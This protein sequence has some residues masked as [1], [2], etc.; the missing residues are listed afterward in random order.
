MIKAIKCYF[1]ISDEALKEEMEGFEDPYLRDIL[2]QL[3]K[4][5]D[6]RQKTISGYCS[7]VQ[8]PDPDQAVF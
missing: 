2:I 5:K 1:R 8:N 4:E 7:L 6:E 3:D